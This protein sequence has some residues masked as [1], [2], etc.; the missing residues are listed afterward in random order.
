MV[1]IVGIVG[2]VPWEHIEDIVQRG[3]DGSH[4][5]YKE[6]YLTLIVIQADNSKERNGYIVMSYCIYK[7]VLERP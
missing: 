5:S 6:A 7:S 1:G 3:V 4:H 2:I